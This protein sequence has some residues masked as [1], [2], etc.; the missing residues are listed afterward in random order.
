MIEIKYRGRIGNRLFQYCL[1]RIIAESKGY[2]LSC[3]PIAGFK[4]T[5]EKISGLSFKNDR[6]CLSGQK[7]NFEG[8]L[9]SNKDEKIFLEGFFCRY[10]YYESHRNQIRTW[11]RMEPSSRGEILKKK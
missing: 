9:S 6:L 5:Y 11:L 2:E 8:I 10:E 3:K 1:D 7:I 4:G